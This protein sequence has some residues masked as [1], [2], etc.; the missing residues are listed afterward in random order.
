[1]LRLG[2]V[3]G[4]DKDE[5]WF[6]GS[7]EDNQRWFCR[8]KGLKDR[9]VVTVKINQLRGNSYIEHSERIPLRRGLYIYNHPPLSYS[10]HSASHSGC[11]CGP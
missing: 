7:L 5:G 8:L 2:Q 6:S 10:A 3:Q 11:V 4:D 1:M 9:A